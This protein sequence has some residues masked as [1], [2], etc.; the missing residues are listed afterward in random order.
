MEVT[1]EAYDDRSKSIR[2]RT[3]TGKRLCVYR[4]TDPDPEHQKANF[5][6]IRYGYASTIYK[7]QGAT[8][9]HVTIWLE[10][11]GLRANA[12]VAMSRV[13]RDD[14]YLFGGKLTQQHFVP[15]V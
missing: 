13:E 12:Y 4:Y 11:P 6:P 10:R 2:V 1:V 7:M 15:N 5:F 8:L 14:Q 3:K 9:P